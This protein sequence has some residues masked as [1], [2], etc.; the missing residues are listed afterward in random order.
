[1]KFT[2]QEA[3]SCSYGRL[4]DL[5]AKHDDDDGRMAK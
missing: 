2:K 4:I 3:L 5:K 1:M